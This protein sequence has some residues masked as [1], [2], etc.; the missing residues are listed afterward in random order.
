MIRRALIPL[1]AVAVMA[2]CSPQSADS[3]GVPVEAVPSAPA[4]STQSDAD[5]AMVGLPCPDSDL[6]ARPIAGGLPATT[7]P[8]LGPGPDVNLAG[9]RGTPVVLNVWASW[10]PP[11]RQEMPYLTDMAAAAGDRLVVLGV[12]VQDTRTAGAA[13]AAEVGLM[14]V[15]DETGKTRATLGWAGPPVTYLVRADGQVA[16]TVYGALPSSQALRELVS[17]HLGVE[18]GDA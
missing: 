11:C 17:T 6:S 4:V 3:A 10:C 16:F 7:L 8:C 9:L 12:D 5:T 18:V 2:G 13:Y 15:Y 14:S 1:V